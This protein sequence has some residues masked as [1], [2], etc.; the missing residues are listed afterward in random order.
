MQW[1]DLERKVAEHTGAAMI[2]YLSEPLAVSMGEQ[3]FEIAA[4][5]HF[6]VVRRFHVLQALGGEI[7]GNAKEIGEI[8]C[9]NGLLQ[10]QIEIGYAR[11]VTGLDLNEYALKRNVSARS[12]VCCYDIRDRKPEFAGSFDLIFLFDVLEHITDEY[13]F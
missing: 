5:D 2:E 6:W 9:G 8:G 10:R 3:W 11:G 12:R 7:I 1:S 13:A 4:M